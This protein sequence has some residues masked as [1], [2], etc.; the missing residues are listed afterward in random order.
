[1]D[2]DTFGKSWQDFKVKFQKAAAAMKK[3][4]LV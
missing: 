1:M 3:E 2:K 4:H